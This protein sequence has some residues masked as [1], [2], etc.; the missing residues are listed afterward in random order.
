MHRRGKT[1]RLDGVGHGCWDCQFQQSHVVIHVGAI[2]GRVD[3]DPLDG[4]DQGSHTRAQHR[5]EAHS[6]VGGARVTGG[7]E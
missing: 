5:S 6:P 2:K 1:D 7:Y 3:D 4:D